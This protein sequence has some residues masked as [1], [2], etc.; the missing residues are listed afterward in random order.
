MTKKRCD[1]C[2]FWEEF[3]IAQD[4][5]SAYDDDG[6]GN[7]TRYPPVFVANDLEQLCNPE[8]LRPYSPMKW[9]QPVTTSRDTCGEFKL[10]TVAASTPVAIE[11]RL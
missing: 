9:Q 1:E 10:K 7:C 3:D 2:N 11:K 5:E 4:D 8:G 6:I